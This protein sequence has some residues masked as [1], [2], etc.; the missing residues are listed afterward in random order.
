MLGRSRKMLRADAHDERARCVDRARKPGVLVGPCRIGSPPAEV[1]GRIGLEQ[2]EAFGRSERAIDAEE[3]ELQLA[4]QRSDD[5]RDAGRAVL[6]KSVEER[7]L[8][9][10]EVDM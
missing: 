2:D 7:A 8:L 6:V 1:H 9:P 3:I 4:L 10:R 5:G